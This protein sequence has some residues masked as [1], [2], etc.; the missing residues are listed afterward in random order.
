MGSSAAKAGGKLFAARFERS[1][2]R[3]E[4][5]INAEGSGDDTA[6]SDIEV[7]K[8]PD[9]RIEVCNCHVDI[10][11]NKKTCIRYLLSEQRSGSY[12]SPARTV[13]PRWRGLDSMRS[14]LALI[15]VTIDHV[16]LAS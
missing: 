8:L 3:G 14:G 13:S 10:G 5:G 7:R 11:T 15:F 2:M 4:S 12:L 6:T 1:C 16:G 9:L